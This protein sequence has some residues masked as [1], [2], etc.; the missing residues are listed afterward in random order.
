MSSFSFPYPFFPVQ[1]TKD[2]VVFQQPDV[3]A[4][5][6]GFHAGVTD[7]FVI[8]H[9]WNNN[10]DDATNLYSGLCAQVAAQIAGVPSLKGRLFVICGIL[11]PSKK[12][13]D[14]DLIPGGAASLNDA[15]SKDQLRARVRDLADLI[16]GKGWPMEAPDPAVESA[17]GSVQQSVGDWED[18]P[19]VRENVVTVIRGLLPARSADAEDASDRFL[20][21]K[22]DLL[23]TNLSR[24]LNPPQNVPQGASAASLD[25]F[26]SGPVSG[27]GGAAGFRDVLGGVQSAFLHLLNFTTYYLMKARAGDVGVKDRKSTRLNS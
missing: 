26:S 8:S 18:D 7:L 23:I 25:P 27:L 13:E 9:G 5:M 24:S 19:S 12:F 22:A 4:L 3:D 21:M 17:L 11:W 10:M 15:V 20:S 6:G 16:Q 2:G 14:Q 1:F